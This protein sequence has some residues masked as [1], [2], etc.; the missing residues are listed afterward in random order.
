MLLPR[1]RATPNAVVVLDASGSWGCGAYGGHNWL[2]LQWAHDLSVSEL[3]I[4]FKELVPVVLAAVT[5]GRQG[6]GMVVLCQS[7]NEA[8]VAVLNTRTSRDAQIMHLL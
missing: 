4:A 2:Q 8:T 7:D 3:S 6:K 1:R 5:W